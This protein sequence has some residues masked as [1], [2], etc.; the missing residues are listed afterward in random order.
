MADRFYC[1][2]LTGTIAQL[3]D[4]EAHHALHV[5]RIKA[6][7]SVQLF[8]GRGTLA[9]GIVTTVSRRDLSIELTDRE[10]HSRNQ[11]TSV[12]VASAVPKG[13]RLKWMLEKLTELGTDRWI[14]LHANRSVRGKE[15]ISPEKLLPTVVAASKQCNRLWLMDIQPVQSLPEILN[16]KA[17]SES[18]LWLAHPPHHRTSAI[19]RIGAGSPDGH[20]LALIGPEGGFDEDEVLQADAAGAMRL[21]WP[22]TILRIETAA[23]MAA[24]ILQAQRSP[25]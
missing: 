5:L 20:H 3:S 18:H 11:N 2:D 21:A 19:P 15:N 25:S 1:P 23:V 24:V 7:A 22:E 17:D 12:T 4:T 9:S 8:D 16:S 13:D 6:G 10:V 14:P